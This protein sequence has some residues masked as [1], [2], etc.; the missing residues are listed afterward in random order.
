MISLLINRTA[1]GEAL[2]ESRK[3]TKTD[4]KAGYIENFGK[5]NLRKERDKHLGTCCYVRGA[6]MTMFK[7]NM[8]SGR[9]PN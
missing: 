8:I 3:I 4:P 9:Q 1:Y 5:R 2:F 7:S 6:E